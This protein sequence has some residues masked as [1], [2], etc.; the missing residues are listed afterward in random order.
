MGGSMAVSTGPKG[1]SIAVG[2]PVPVGA[3]L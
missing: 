3:M 2:G 1:S